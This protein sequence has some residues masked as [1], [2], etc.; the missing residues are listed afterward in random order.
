MQ[1]TEKCT[2]CTK[3]LDL[4]INF[5]YN[6]FVRGCKKYPINCYLAVSNGLTQSLLQTTIYNAG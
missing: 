5:C 1:N 3:T 6:K 2:M 4:K